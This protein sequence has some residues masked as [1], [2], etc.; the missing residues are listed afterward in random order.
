MAED[1]KGRTLVALVWFLGLFLVW[2]FASLLLIDVFHTKGAATKLPYP[3]T[4][5]VTMIQNF[6]MLMEA[7]AITFSRAF[8]GFV[9]G[10]GVGIALAVIMSLSKTVERIA[11]PYLII[12][13]M[14]PVLGLAPIIF[15]IVK[16]MNTSRIAIAAYITFFPVAANMLSGLKSVEQEKKDLM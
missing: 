11:F 12:S 8:V 7:G 14:I 3:H 2:E 16:D 13:Q 5:I 15:N 6:K 10:T 1:K 4:I 9:L